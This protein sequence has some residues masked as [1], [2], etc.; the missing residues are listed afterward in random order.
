MRNELKSKR[1]PLDQAL[2]RESLDLPRNACGK[3]VKPGN[4]PFAEGWLGSAGA[5]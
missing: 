4:C 2:R 3:T 5:L 1:C